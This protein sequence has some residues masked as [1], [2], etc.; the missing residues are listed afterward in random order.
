MSREIRDGVNANHDVH[1]SRLH[2]KLGYRHALLIR[3]AVNK[4]QPF[5]LQIL[6]VGFPRKVIERLLFRP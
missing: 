3:R 6:E 1:V 2:K 5:G 4:L